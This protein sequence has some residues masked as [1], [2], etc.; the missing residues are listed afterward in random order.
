MKKYV[1]V[2]CREVSF[3]VGDMVYLKLQPYQQKSLAKKE[4]E[5]LSPKFFGPYEI[6]EKIGEVAYRLRLPPSTTIHNVF[7]VSQLKKVVGEW[8]N[9][10]SSK[11]K[12]KNGTTS[13]L[14]LH[15]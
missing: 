13:N 3:E 6:I 5:K 1:D 4:C 8:D 15:P 12:K 11:K 7:H 9:I 2:K 14:K 10:H